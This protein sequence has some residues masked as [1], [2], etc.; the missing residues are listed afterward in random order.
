MSAV[1]TLQPCVAGRWVPGAEQRPVH[2]PYD[3]RLLAQVGFCGP[4]E[5]DSALSGAA[6]AE[7][8]A[9][10]LTCQERAR[11]CTHVA[12]ALGAQREEIAL[13]ITDESGKPIA[14]A[15]GEVDRAI[16]TFE[17]AAAEAGRAAREG[18]LLPMDLRPGGQGRL[19]LV[20]RVP[21]GTV[22]G[23]TPFNF[24]LNLV[25]H[26]IAPALAA[27]C[28]ILLKPAEQTPL[29]ALRLAA[30]VLQ[31]GWPPEALSV[32]P[33][34]RTVAEQLVV[35]ERP[36]M[37]SFTG[38]A[39]VGWAL[40]SRAGR[41]RVLLELG[42]DA[43]VIIDESVTE[44]DI[45]RMLPKLVY[46]AYSYAGQKCISIQRIFVV[47]AQGTRH[48]QLLDRLAAAV[49]ALRVGD[50][51]DPEVM[52][53][54]MIDE[55]NARRI[56]DW[57]A[58]AVSLGAQLLCGGQRQGTLV[59]PALLRNVPPGARL[60]REEAFGPVCFVER[61]ADFSAALAAV[62]AS[63][64]GLQAALFTRDLGHSLR[65]FDELAVGAVI[66]NDTPSFRMDHM[67]YGGVKESGLGREGVRWAIQEMTETRLLVTG[68]L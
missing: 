59:Q 9:A 56:Q 28:P 41:K 52:V 46:G 15:R 34:D 55:A 14:E 20:R 30:L 22:V 17:L 13:G 24:P 5:L 25:A 8:A 58:E 6:R 3:G 68:T 57:I 42:G 31:A 44:A 61:V 53:G 18:L 23:I 27:G 67:P 26:K 1:P 64:Y 60:Y 4:A 11:I 49:S 21:V 12:A 36:R 19:G 65:A 48:A 45:E 37:L 43:A 35:D 63:R 54:P 62:N 39:P 33:A 29:T 2:A 38:S 16:H 32:V 51:R 47:D 7:A 66:L 50:P 10:S 40:K